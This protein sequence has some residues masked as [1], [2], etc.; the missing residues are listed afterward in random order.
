MRSFVEEHFWSK[1]IFLYTD[2]KGA[3][4]FAFATLIRVPDLW[5][6]VSIS[7]LQ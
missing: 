7:V 1:V 6:R 2:E 4:E 3:I 5:N